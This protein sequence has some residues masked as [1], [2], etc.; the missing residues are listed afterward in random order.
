MFD[1]SYAAFP[2]SEAWKRASLL[3]NLIRRSKLF[4]N[5]LISYINILVVQTNVVGEQLKKIYKI[6][7]IKVI[8]NTVSLDHLNQRINR[9]FK[10]NNCFNLLC[11]SRYYS[12]KNMEIF[13]PLAKLIISS[14]Q[15][16]KIILTISGNESSKAKSLLKKIR[17]NNLN[18]VI[19]NIGPVLMEHVPSL[20]EQTDALIMPTLLESF[21]APM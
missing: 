13:I 20:Y 17:Y 5:Y 4:F 10:L 16:I 21:L 15:N 14:G 8:S 12:H 7:N 3:E 6:N 2:D 9:N 1:W 11:L 19:I 18:S